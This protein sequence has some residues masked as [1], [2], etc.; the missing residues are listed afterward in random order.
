MPPSYITSYQTPPR[1]L[2]HFLLLVF[3][4]FLA[5]A[6]F[7]QGRGCGLRCQALCLYWHLHRVAPPAPS[8]PLT[9]TISFYLLREKWA[10]GFSGVLKLVSSLSAGVNPTAAPMHIVPHVNTLLV[11]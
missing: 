6:L 4:L 7:L 8:P 3:S 5:T 10:R 11:R 9:H 1:I 2:S